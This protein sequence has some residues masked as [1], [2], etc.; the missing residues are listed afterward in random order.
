MAATDIH[1]VL[2][3]HWGHDSFRSR[4][5]EIVR[6]VMKGRDTLALLPTGAGK[7]IC[8][9]VL[10]LA[11]GRM[12]LVVSPLIALMKDQVAGL[13]K[14][15]ISAVAITSGMRR[16]EMDNALESC[17]AGKRSFLYVS[18]ERL[19]TDLFKARLPRL[20]IGL[21]AVD[22][23]H[24]ISQWGYD[25]R[26]AYL[27]VSEVREALPDVPVL[28]L[29]ASATPRVADDIMARLAFREKNLVKASFR[30]EEITYWTSSGEDK[31]GRLL[32]IAQRVEGTGV[33][34]V[35]ERKGTLRIARMLEQH[36]ISAAA[37]HAGMEMA[38]RD[39]V[40]RA[41]SDCKVRFVVATTAFGMGIDKAD[42]R[43]VVH[44]EPP[45]DPESY[46]QEAG[47]AGRDG[48]RSHAILLHSA[49]DPERLRECV[50]GSFPP[51]ADVRRVYQAFAD[52]H[53]IA[54]GT[55]QFETYSLDLRSLAARV[56]LRPVEVAN[57]LKA[58]E[59]DGGIV[60]SD[61]A[62][63][64]SRVLITAPQDVVYSMRV[65][66]QRLGPL[67]ESLLRMH[68]G[69][70]EE[71]VMIEEERLARHLEWPLTRV[72]N[73]LQELQQQGVVFYAQ[74]RDGPTV[75][76]LTPR[77]D[78]RT[79]MLDPEALTARKQR[80]L[81]RLDAMLHY[82]G[83]GIPCREQ[84]LLFYFGEE[85]TAACGRCDACK[86]RMKRVANAAMDDA[87]LRSLDPEEAE[88]AHWEVQEGFAPATKTGEHGM[89]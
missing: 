20:P 23:A 75:T 2:K 47:R 79:L 88:R 73:G 52:E 37:Y 63:D 83:P 72:V 25:F 32:R 1:E 85:G 6:S 76:L 13:K 67:L 21:V 39:R 40:Q 26:P 50:G 87:A 68:G 18:P 44:M 27:R 56:E 60:M 81:E 28:A 46:Y 10:A 17:A 61:G 43:V 64:P 36:G 65:G 58:I 19:G 78:V 74:R 70:F 7:S 57:A 59:L 49:G 31:L 84:A 51:I 41:W 4:Q 9:Q 12:C 38:E 54:V 48:K 16:E 5:E 55:A 69:L 53:R 35:R 29:T 34:Y 71:P 14:R 42:V 89:D 24:C 86:A 45:A 33:V 77:R 30:R 3:T 22:E 80:A 66:D 62:R 11:M 8:F 82:L 15:G